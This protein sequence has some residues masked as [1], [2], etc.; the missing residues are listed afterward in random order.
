M[1]WKYTLSNCVYLRRAYRDAVIV[2]DEEIVYREVAGGLEIK[3]LNGCGWSLAGF[4]ALRL[5][6]PKR[7][8]TVNVCCTQYS[9]HR[10]KGETMVGIDGVRVQW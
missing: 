1:Q 3:Y 6:D 10:R 8:S 5:V 9:K 4:G 2:N 7:F